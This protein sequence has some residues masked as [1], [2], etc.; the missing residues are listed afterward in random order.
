MFHACT[1]ECEPCAQSTKTAKPR[2]RAPH[3]CL[4]CRARKVRC[5]VAERWPCGNC[6]WASCDCVIVNRGRVVR[7]ANPFD[8]GESFYRTTKSWLTNSS[9]NRYSRIKTPVC[10]RRDASHARLGQRHGTGEV[11]AESAGF[12]SDLARLD[13]SSDSIS[14]ARQPSLRDSVQLS[15]S[16]SRKCYL[17]RVRPARWLTQDFLIQATSPLLEFNQA[18]SSSQK[19]SLEARLLTKPTSSVSTDK[20][21]S[22]LVVHLPPFVRTMPGHIKIEDLTYLSVKGALTL[23]RVPLQEALS[24]SYFEYVHPFMPILDI[25][26]FLESVGSNGKGDQ[27]SLLLYQAIMFAGAAYVDMDCLEKEG[28]FSR[29]HAREEL[30]HRAKLLY[31]FNYESHRLVLVQSLLLMSLWHGSPEEH[32]DTWHWKDV[33]ISQA[34]AAGLHLNPDNTL[35]TKRVCRLRRRVWW[36]CYATDRLIA[37]EMKRLPRIRGDDFHVTALE[38]SDFRL[39]LLSQGSEILPQTMCGYVLDENSRATLGKLCIEL[40]QLCQYLDMSL[41]SHCSVFLGDKSK[42]F[43][44][45]D[46]HKTTDAETGNNS[47]YSILRQNLKVWKSA[48]PQCCQYRAPSSVDT[49]ST[50]AVHHT[51]LHMLF[52]SMMLSIHLSNLAS[53]QR[54]ANLTP[55][56]EEARLGVLGAALQISQ[57]AGNIHNTRLDRFLPTTALLAVIPAASVLL[58][59]VGN[60]FGP[61]NYVIKN[62]FLRCLGVIDTMKNVY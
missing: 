4:S 5:D 25:E 46:E 1:H 27:V 39:E 48:L 22:T 3:A 23:P 35:F 2:R 60:E 44:W 58:R 40:V 8:S 24:R 37:L 47:S 17:G 7:H 43:F 50:I 42:M 49:S 33:A 9:S 61:E 21:N 15:L 30:F 29:K 16:D 57:M 52:Q 62:G 54:S 55:I 53:V 10:A 41:L 14:S 38:D 34:F 26:Q 45:S 28:F 18:A 56:E 31:D 51:S 36:S 19:V 11:K 6:R 59:E 13:K 32:R 12:R 20:L